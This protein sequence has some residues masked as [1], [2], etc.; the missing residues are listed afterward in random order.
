MEYQL[1]MGVEQHAQFNKA[2]E[3]WMWFQNNPPLGPEQKWYYP[4]GFLRVLKPIIGLSVG[5]IILIDSLAHS[6]IVKLATAT[7]KQEFIN[8][9][10]ELNTHSKITPEQNLSFEKLTTKEIYR[11]IPHMSARIKHLSGYRHWA[12]S[13]PEWICGDCARKMPIEFKE[14]GKY[15]LQR[16][17]NCCGKNKAICNN[18]NDFKP[19][20]R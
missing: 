10:P 6:R 17:C 4:R 12:A 3:E 7:D 15:K 11:I 20:G 16:R 14:D 13:L 5:D 2:I 18:R 8:H 1:L 9:S 19:K